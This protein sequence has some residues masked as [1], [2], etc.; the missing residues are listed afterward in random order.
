MKKTVLRLVVVF[1]VLLT[2]VGILA[3]CSN[4][5]CV[6]EVSSQSKATCQNDGV[7]LYK[8][9][10][11]G[12][13][14]TKEVKASEL[15]H[16]MGEENILHTASCETD[17]TLVSYCLYG[18]GYK[19]ERADV[20]TRYGHNY[21]D[22]ISKDG[23]TM[24]SSCSK[25]DSF[26]E[27]PVP[28]KTHTLSLLKGDSTSYSETDLFKCETCEVKFEIDDVLKFEISNASQGYSVKISSKIQTVQLTTVGLSAIKPSLNSTYDGEF[29][30]ET[31]EDI[32]KNA[33]ELII[34]ENISK[35]YD[36]FHFETIRRVT[37]DEDVTFLASKTFVSCALLSEIYM[38]GDCPEHEESTFFVASRE[39]DSENKTGL[40][41]PT[42]Y[43][44]DGKKGYSGI[45]LQGCTLLAVGEIIPEVPQMSID[46]YSN[47]AAEKAE[48]YAEYFLKALAQSESKLHLLP[49]ASLENYAPIYTLANELTKNLTSEKEKTK[50]IFDWITKNITYDL[51]AQ[52]YP[53]ERVF[54]EKRAVCN[55]YVLLMHDM[56]AAVGI[57][58]AYTHG[59]S[60]AEITDRLTVEEML[61][62]SYNEY[63]KG[64]AWIYIYADGGLVLCDPTW[65]EFDI[66][67]E[68]LATNRLTTGFYGITVAP[69]EI[70]PR[71]YKEYI[72][73]ENNELIYLLDGKLTQFSSNSLVFNYSMTVTYTYVMSNSGYET[74]GG[75][76]MGE[77][78]T[79]YK[80][81]IIEYSN[82]GYLY[83]SLFDSAYNTYNYIDVLKGIAFASLNG[84]EASSNIIG[85]DSYVFDEYG[86]IYLILS[87]T[88]LELIGT[89]CPDSELTVPSKVGAR[90]VVGIGWG[91]F[92]GCY[93]SEI[94]LPSTVTY[95]KSTAFW[96]CQNLIEIRIPNSV[97]EL[98]VSLFTG[99]VNL[100]KIYL[101][102][103]I[104]QIGLKTTNET[105]V[106]Y[107]MF[108]EL[109]PETLSVYYDGT[110]EE[111]DRINFYNPWGNEEDGYFDSEHYEHIIP[112][113]VFK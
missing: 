26:E 31:V 30:Y 24:V 45:K 41:S 12:D 51:G 16:L 76:F 100:E 107:S 79:A 92:S 1:A 6:Y 70:D 62:G 55:G 65:N 71:C 39:L 74:I 20:G 13:S 66:T 106:P 101:P 82:M 112:F 4:H 93:A 17:D 89:V 110:K 108:S 68:H 56:L 40:Y 102:S 38:E 84:I 96:N 97:K 14:Y 105:C 104:E 109:S 87:D 53:V 3:S 19:K 60:T 49:Y 33:S 21:G 5:V 81:A 58:S 48:E 69:D 35:I 52:Y 91:A 27:K 103:S 64:H 61:N 86:N 90:D 28:E 37:I 42:V 43:Y 9:M 34:G 67:T 78:L 25:C 80:N 99:C 46:E 63:N 18:C 36:L 15:Y 88:A 77:L 83:I 85:L 72:L 7:D 59:I 8:C 29:N 22:F 73:Y 11:C 75:E 95:I 111:F 23:E 54:E 44:K 2:F 57:T 32:A 10:S 47:K 113:M 94:I 98:G 50:A